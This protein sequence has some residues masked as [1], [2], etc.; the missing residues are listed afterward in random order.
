MDRAEFA[1]PGT[2]YRGVTLWMLNDELE[3]DEIARQLK[4]LYNAGWG[5]MIG[6]TFNGLLT[7][8]MSEEW[9]GIIREI[10]DG[11]KETGMK[12]W[13]QA[14]YM[15]SGIPDLKDEQK[16]RVVARK[17]KDEEPEEGDTLLC[18]DDEYRYYQ[19]WTC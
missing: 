15:P 19:C 9:M 4:G 3:R 1:N 11:A 14:G 2:A 8:Y 6:R 16:Y 10:V 7:E 18:E 17:A 13:L 12:V 5:A